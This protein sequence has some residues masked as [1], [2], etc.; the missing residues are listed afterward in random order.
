MKKTEYYAATNE[1]IE[2]EL[3]EA[4]IAQKEQDALDDKRN[5][6]KELADLKAKEAAKAALLD[7]LGITADEAKLLLS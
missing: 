5:K 3:S 7:R 4:E 6:A 1:T 2:A